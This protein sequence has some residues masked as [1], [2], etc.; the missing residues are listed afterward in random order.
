MASFTWWQ[1]IFVNI[2]SGATA[3]IIGASCAY[4]FQHRSRIKDSR[5]QLLSS[6]AAEVNVVGK[7]AAEYWATET[8]DEKRAEKVN[9]AVEIK[10]GI[11]SIVDC[12]DQLK[13]WDLIAEGH[14]LDVQLHKLYKETT[15]D[16]FEGAWQKANPQKGQLVMDL[17]SGVR[18]TLLRSLGAS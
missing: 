8:T 4:W 10:C 7:I 2:T 6:T 18:I 14:E 5:L 12:V 11:K 9:Q 13:N 16:D 3:A 15:S 17:A 1:L